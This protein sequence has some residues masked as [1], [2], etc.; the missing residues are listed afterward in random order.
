MLGQDHLEKIF[1]AALMEYGCSVELGTELV[2]FEQ[3]DGSVRVKL[4]KKGFSDDEETWIAEESVYEWMV[5]ADG[6]RGVVRK[7]LGLSF[8][9]E[10]RSVE[11]FIV[12]DIYVKGISAKVGRPCA[13][14]T[15]SN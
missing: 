3:A 2:S 15:F 9:G 5:G 7:Q 14:I 10:S 11:N 8:L 4:I 1:H 6:A 12:G 13:Q